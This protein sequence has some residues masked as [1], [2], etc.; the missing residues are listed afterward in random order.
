MM[1]K[2]SLG[3]LGELDF[4]DWILG[5]WSALISGG[6]GAVVSGFAVTLSDPEHFNLSSHKLYEVIFTA[7]IAGG[8][9]SGMNFLRQRP[10]P[11]V[12]TVVTTVEKTEVLK[13]PAAKVV[14]TV[15]ESHEEPI[16][17]VEKGTTLKP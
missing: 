8:I 17:P 10:A 4:S 1:T 12:K 3:F 5:L 2:L 15:Q 11:S 16:V 13:N 7:F 9:L 6:A 14:T